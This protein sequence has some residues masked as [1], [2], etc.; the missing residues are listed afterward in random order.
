MQVRLLCSGGIWRESG[1]TSSC[2]HA[3]RLR[4]L[5]ATGVMPGIMNP[6]HDPEGG[7]GRLPTPSSAAHCILPSEPKSLLARNF[8]FVRLAKDL[9]FIPASSFSSCRSVSFAPCDAH[10][11]PYTLDGGNA[12]ETGKSLW[13]EDRGCT[14]ETA[15]LIYNLIL[16]LV[17]LLD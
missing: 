12:L 6:R 10:G 1:L 2:L 13:G 5:S 14:V 9:D 11:G 8:L 7:V 17:S 4:G 16:L 3:V 15:C